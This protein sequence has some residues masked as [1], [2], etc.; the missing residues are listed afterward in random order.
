MLLLR[1]SLLALAALVGTAAGAAPPLP[2]GKAETPARAA[3]FAQAYAAICRD[4]DMTMAAMVSRA[5]AQG[6]VVQPEKSRTMRRAFSDNQVFTDVFALFTAG[7]AAKPIL[8]FATLSETRDPA[9]KPVDFSCELR[10]PASA[11]APPKAEV[12]AVF[13]AVNAVLPGQS[14]QLQ[15]ADTPMGRMFAAEQR[16]DKFS[17]GYVASVGTHM[18]ARQ[19]T[20]PVAFVTVPR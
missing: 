9:G 10:L 3:Q 18:L 20:P 8:L 15:P 2:L 12:Q 16:G 1:V 19:P 7:D 14:W 17:E 11:I 5:Q 4:A 6:F 13:K